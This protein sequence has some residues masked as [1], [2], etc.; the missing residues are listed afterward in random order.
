VNTRIPEPIDGIDIHNHVYPGKDGHLDRARAESL[1]EGCSRLGI[2]RLCVS[3]PLT[4]EQPSPDDVRRANDIVI[5]AM[6]YS[7]RFIGFC[8]VNPGYARAAVAEMERCIRQGGM[9]GTKLYHQYF[10]CDPAQ[11][12]VMECAADLGVPVLMHA[13]KVMDA[14]T[15]R[16][17]PRLSHAEHF[18][19]AV[20]MFP[21]TTLIQGHIGGGGDWEWNLRHLE[22]RCGVYLDISGSVVDAGIVARTVAALGAE[23]VLFATDGSL[24]EGVGKLLAAGLSD[25][26]LALICQGNAE[27]ILGLRRA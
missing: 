6:A 8:F 7:D 20:R 1:L 14:P 18:L 10:V 9:R 24:E 12:A 13:G 16:Q 17:Q 22:T 23:H 4:S 3:H 2:R 15:R 11:T 26:D 25:A 19:Q 21:R 5:E 27:R